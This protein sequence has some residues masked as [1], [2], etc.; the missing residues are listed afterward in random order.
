MSDPDIKNRTIIVIDVLGDGPSNH[1]LDAIAGDWHMIGM[2]RG[3]YEL[4]PKE[5][6]RLLAD[7]RKAIMPYTK[8]GQNGG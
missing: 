6:E 8:N 1:E 4:H 3:K 7:I 2:P 5:V